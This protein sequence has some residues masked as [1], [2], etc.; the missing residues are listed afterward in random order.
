MK[1]PVEELKVGDVFEL[2]N[3]NL[4]NKSFRVVEISKVPVY[5]AS[6]FAKVYPVFCDCFDKEENKSLGY[7]TMS[8]EIKEVELLFRESEAKYEPFNLPEGKE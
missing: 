5:R 8:E 7:R 2:T 6:D 4:L 1:I 3:Y